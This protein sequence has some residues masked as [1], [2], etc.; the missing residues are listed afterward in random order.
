M[1]LQIQGQAAAWDPKL[2]QSLP[3][4]LCPVKGGFPSPADDFIEQSLDLNR[5]LVHHPTSTYFVRVTGDSMEEAGI[6]SGDL[7]VVDTSIP[8]KEGM[9]VIASLESGLTVKRLV[10]RS[11]NA[12]ALVAA[13]E[14]YPA[15][16]LAE[17][18][19]VV[20]WGVVVHAIHSF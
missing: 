6:H 19:D 10:K 14:R 20:V 2:E 16:E 12:W 7:L 17:E 5:H 4:Y 18:I 9:V 13:N 3:L 15:F 11:E 1:Q 8:P